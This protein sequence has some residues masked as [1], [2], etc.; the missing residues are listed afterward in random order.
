MDQDEIIHRFI[1]KYN[2]C[3]D[4]VYEIT[5]WPDKENRNARACDAYA[6]ADDHRPLA[7]EHT[8]IETFNRQLLDSA[9]FMKVIG[10]LED[11][12]KNAFTCRTTFIV[13]TFAIQPGT[14]WRLIKTALRQ[15]LLD[16]VPNLPE[17][18]SKHN[19]EGVPFEVTVDID[20]DKRQR[21]LFF[22]MRWEPPN[23]DNYDQLTESIAA[24]LTDK[25]DQLRTYRTVTTYRELEV[26]KI[27]I[28][29]S[30]DIA[31]ASPATL[32]KAF[33][34]ARD[35]VVSNNIDQV[36]VAN[37]YQDSCN[38]ECFQGEEAIMERANPENFHLG[39]RYADEWAE[40]IREDEVK[41]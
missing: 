3:Q 9:R 7:I 8:N 18:R 33:L 23:L 37:T 10:E 24:A 22:V 36:W 11:E 27:L 19:I 35:R 13:P 17:G 25:N 15:W 4:G 30:Q 32:Y 41:F 12:L 26:K 34:K 28:L 14:D 29:E 1:A 31:L 40:A 2:E 39:P 6:E 38:F 5:R 20:R 16:N 21:S